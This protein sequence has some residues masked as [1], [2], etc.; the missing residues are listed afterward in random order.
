MFFMI[1]G[2]TIVYPCHINGQRVF[3]VEIINI[4]RGVGYFKGILGLLY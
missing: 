4:G 3:Q 2:Y 1:N